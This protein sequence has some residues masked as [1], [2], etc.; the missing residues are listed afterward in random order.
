MVAYLSF[1]YK[2]LEKGY[3]NMGYQ[4]KIEFCMQW[5]FAPKAA[6]LAGDL[7]SHFRFDIE[8]IELIPSSGGVFE[9]YVNEEKIYSKI[10]K[11]VFPKLE[12][13]M[14]KLQGDDK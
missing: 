13:I 6:S 10:E 5:N 12:D 14:Y 11:G 7:F 9:V 8:K 1:S 2:I 3:M 4:V